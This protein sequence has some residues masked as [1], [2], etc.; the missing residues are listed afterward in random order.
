[1]EGQ[2]RAI[3]AFKVGFWDKCLRSCGIRGGT[4]GQKTG[5]HRA[6]KRFKGKWLAVKK[7]VDPELIIWENYGIGV[8]QRLG[9]GCTFWLFFIGILMFCLWSVVNLEN[10]N[11]VLD[12]ATPKIDCKKVNVTED[13]AI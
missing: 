5:W 4:S 8:C 9:R 1:M 11:Q 10:R 7:A 13:L 3:D 2:A 12:E 6:D